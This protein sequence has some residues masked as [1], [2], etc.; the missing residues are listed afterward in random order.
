MIQTW[1]GPTALF[2]VL[3][4]AISHLETGNIRS[5]RGALGVSGN[6]LD[7]LDTLTLLLIG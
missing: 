4:F 5:E 1:P 7:V 3:A 6:E 2:D